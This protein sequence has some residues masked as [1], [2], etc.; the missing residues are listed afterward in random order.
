MLGLLV[1]D[2]A[3]P[4]VPGD[5]GAPETFPFPVRR[6]VVRGAGVEGVVHAPDRALLPRFI[7]AAQGL[8]ADGCIGIATTCGFL[9]AWQD[10]L[11]AAV[12]VPV[13]ASPL[14]QWPLVQRTLPR[15][16]RAGIVTYS[17]AALTP[18]VLAG[19]GIPAGTPVAGVAPDGYFARTIR[20][21]APALDASRMADDVVAAARALVAEHADIGAIVL[22]CANM[23][24]YAG[25]VACATGLPTFDAVDLLAWFHTAAARVQRSG[26]PQ[27]AWRTVPR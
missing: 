13:L 18:A 27:Y 24:P 9:A 2:T 14:L 11:A 8:Q 19:A 25:A 3:F 4:R 10:E 26:E 12:D 7:A 15:G 21:G 23:P 6:A 22:E 16:R 20:N 5:V 17:A 1:L